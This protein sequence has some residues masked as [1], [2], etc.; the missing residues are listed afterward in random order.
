MIS[1]AVILAGGKGTRLKSVSGD[2]PKPLVYVA[3]K[4]VIEH[5]FD[6]CI[7]QGLTSCYLLVH[8]ESKY[9]SDTLGSL[10]H[11]ALG[12]LAISYIEETEAL[13]T[14]GALLQCVAQLPERFVLLYADTILNI[15]LERMLEFHKN[16]ESFLTILV[17]PNSHPHD[18]DIVLVDAQGRVASISGYPHS[19]KVELPNLVNAA[20]SIVERKALDALGGVYKKEDFCKVTIP[21][22]L[23]CNVP[24]FSYKSR[25]YIKDMG[26][27][28]RLVQVERDFQKGAVQEGSYQSSVRALF[29]DRDGTLTKTLDYVTEPNQIELNEGAAD[30]LKAARAENF[31]NILVTNQPVVAR[32][33]VDFDGLSLI[34]NRLEKLLG[35][36][37]AFLDD[38]YFCPHHPDSGFPNEIRDLKID[39]DCR[40]P[41]PG[42]LTKAA[43]ELNIDLA[44]SWMVGDSTVDI[45]AG[46]AAGI[47]TCLLLT[48]LGGRDGKSPTRADFQFNDFSELK[49]FLFLQYERSAEQVKKQILGSPI[50]SKLKAVELILVGGNSRSG[51]STFSSLLCEQLQQCY[52]VESN[53]VSMDGWLLSSF[54]RKSGLLGRYD[55]D[56]IEGFAERWLRYAAKEEFVIPIYNPWEKRPHAKF[57]TLKRRQVLILEGVPALLSDRLRETAQYSFFIDVEQR[58]L[59]ERVISFYKARG[60]EG[61]EAEKIYDSRLDEEYALI[62]QTRELAASIFKFS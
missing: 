39:C 32:G 19:D 13:G 25:E 43:N 4:R 47:R 22:M 15:D 28:E 36:S 55:M 46:K 24:V 57:E 48:G 8:H 44:R 53:V 9:F 27:P 20:F 45:A 2:V 41:L 59:R 12:K 50:E 38:I 17:H 7:A 42:M 18:S 1:S 61:N 3:G 26:T 58:L 14:G 30:F 54:E 5:Q 40:K 11:T 34:H 35:L 10:Y 33:E 23:A 60:V 6:W 21:R 51:K 29:L 62:D 52:G 56:S 31:L 49:R 37:G 16:K